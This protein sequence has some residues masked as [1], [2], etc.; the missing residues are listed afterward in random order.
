MSINTEILEPTP[1]VKTVRDSQGRTWLCDA[2]ADLDRDLHSQA[3]V[4]AE[5]FIYDRNFGG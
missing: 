5:D 4:L 2:S 3:C 1:N